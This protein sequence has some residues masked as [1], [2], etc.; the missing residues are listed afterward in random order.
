MHESPAFKDAYKQVLTCNPSLD[1]I[2]QQYVIENEVVTATNRVLSLGRQDAQITYSNIAE[3]VR[4]AGTLPGQRMVIFVSP[5]FVALEQESMGFES[6]V[7]RSRGPFQC[8]RQRSRCPRVVRRRPLR[9]CHPGG[10][11]MTGSTV[12][13]Q[14]DYYRSSML[15]ADSTMGALPPAPEAHSFTTATT[16]E[17]DSNA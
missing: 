8:H 3:F 6:R 7:M 4:S 9:G 11:T 14:S 16:W 13:Q 1:P 12:Q 17:P 10:P 5:G 15:I 2:H